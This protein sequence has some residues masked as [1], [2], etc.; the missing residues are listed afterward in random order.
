[1][2]DA[3]FASIPEDQVNHLAE[4]DPVFAKLQKF[5]KKREKIITSILFLAE[6]IPI[7]GGSQLQKIQHSITLN[8]TQEIVVEVVSILLIIQVAA[9]LKS[10][11]Y[12]YS[13]EV[14]IN[15]VLALKIISSLISPI[16]TLIEKVAHTIVGDLDRERYIVE[17]VLRGDLQEAEEREIIDRIE[18][19]FIE[20]AF[21][22]SENT[23]SSV[24]TFMDKVFAI[25]SDKEYSVDE[26]IHMFDQAHSRVPIVGCNN[27]KI[28][29]SGYVLTKELLLGILSVAKDLPERFTFDQL[30]D[31]V[32]KSKYKNR[33]NVY[34]GSTIE[35]HESISKVWKL[36]T[37]KQI[38][39][40][41]TNNSSLAV[42]THP[43]SGLL[44]GIVT[45]TDLLQELV[46]NP[47]YDEDDH[48]PVKQINLLSP[49][50]D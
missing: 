42:V 43:R 47:L 29:C 35:E 40:K 22:F 45:L 25:H 11:G 4:T 13:K 3:A 7:V 26:L 5:L 46:G 32:E 2:V 23:V 30:V 9:I 8:S 49:A 31:C 6:V 21:Q 14:A 38:S 36:F 50:T 34:P 15:S 33:I 27:L 19:G 1:M 39:E 20:N 37:T 41:A 44:L 16:S 10:F 17:A 28:E 12:K 18:H 24:M 48:E